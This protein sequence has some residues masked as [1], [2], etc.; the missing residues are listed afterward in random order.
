M[1]TI[2]DSIDRLMPRSRWGSA[3]MAVLVLLPFMLGLTLLS[4]N[5]WE[6]YGWALFIGIPFVLGMGSALIY[7]YHH[8]RSLKDYMV[9]AMM[10][11]S[12]F[13]IGLMA[14]AMEGLICIM[15]AF[16]LGAVLGLFGA[17][18]GW[19]FQRG[20]NNHHVVPT[21]TVLLLSLPVMMGFDVMRD[22]APPLFSVRT[23]IVIDAPKDKVWENVIAFSELPDPDEWLFKAGVAYPV[24]AV[25]EGH[26]VG[27]IRYCRFKIGNYG[28]IISFTRSI[29]AC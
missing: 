20:P 23:S 11:L 14:L 13:S 6:V 9:V 10:A 7:G 1:N 18:I 21:I 3:A 22:D 27:A 17:I 2:R 5:V 29:S 25:I 8:P 12:L 15:M 24:R 26:G 28:R 16:P 19:T 4:V